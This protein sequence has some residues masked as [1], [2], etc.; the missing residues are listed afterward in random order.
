MTWLDG[1]TF[2]TV[3]VHTT[4]DKSIRGL[5]QAVYD[6]GLL[7]RDAVYL[8]GPSVESMPAYFVGREVFRGMQIIGG[9]T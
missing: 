6:D 4:D 3:I 5:K 1:L 7:L 8:D 9:T 2:E